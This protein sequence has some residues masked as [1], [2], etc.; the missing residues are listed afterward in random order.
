MLVVMG[1]CWEGEGVKEVQ[2]C[3]LSVM[4]FHQV[5]QLARDFDAEEPCSFF[6]VL[7]LRLRAFCRSFTVKDAGRSWF[8]EAAIQS[9]GHAHGRAPCPARLPY[10]HAELAAACS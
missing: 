4:Y 2:R 10:T 9:C 8:L 1:D 3:V 7:T 6:P 5:V